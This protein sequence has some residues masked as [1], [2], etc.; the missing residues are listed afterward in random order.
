ML[1]SLTVP[2]D[3]ED[4]AGILAL[5]GRDDYALDAAAACLLGGSFA[6]RT[7]PAPDRYAMRSAAMLFYP[8]LRELADR[9]GY[10]RILRESGLEDYWKRSGSQP[11]FRRS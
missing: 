3:A 4:G 8:S 10:A 9:P 1:E 11:D 5:L 7:W 2:E 6:G